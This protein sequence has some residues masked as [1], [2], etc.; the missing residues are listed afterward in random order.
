MFLTLLGL[1]PGLSIHTSHSLGNKMIDLVRD[2]LAAFI[3]ILEIPKILE[4]QLELS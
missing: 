1:L 4:K 3:F 2:H